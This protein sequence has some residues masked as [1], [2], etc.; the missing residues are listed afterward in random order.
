MKYCK[1]SFYKSA[2]DVKGGDT[3]DISALFESIRL[4]GANGR[5]K[6]IVEDIRQNPVIGKNRKLELPV[7]MWQGIFSHRADNGLISLSSLMCIDIDHKA[8]D[9]LSALR[10]SLI[11]EPWIVAIFRSPSGDG[12]K[13][14][15]KTDNYKRELYKNCYR[16]LERMFEQRYGIATDNKC[17]A[18]SQGCFASYDPAIYV[19]LDAQ[20]LH[21]SYDPTFDTP[22]ATT[23]Q[24][25]VAKEYNT[26]P[27]SLVAAFLSKLGNGLSDEDII[28]IA[29]KRFARYPNRYKDGYR[30]KSIFVQAS[31]LCKGGISIEKAI[32][33]L[34][35]HYLPT[36][37][38]ECKL[39]Y[40]ARRAYQKCGS[41]FGIERGNYR[42]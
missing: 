32:A 8:E 35:E 19:N 23:L 36:G 26:Q 31:I 37:F 11:Q 41:S 2:T 33:Y 9:E 25:T 27:P 6:S 1:V 30:T 38:D 34:K 18:I 15:V 4:G 14:I 28:E 12:M 42:P 24:K 39:E 13:I 10:K 20:D 16:Q 3:A 40:E 29:D 17:E 7:I 21:L 5:I 22:I